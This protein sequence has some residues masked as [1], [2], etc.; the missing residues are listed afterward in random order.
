MRRKVARDDWE[1]KQ[2]INLENLPAIEVEEGTSSVDVFMSVFDALLGGYSFD[3]KCLHK[4]EPFI[5]VEEASVESH[6]NVDQFVENVMD[7]LHWSDDVSFDE[8]RHV[9]EEVLSEYGI[10]LKSRDVKYLK[11]L[12]EQQIR[13]QS[14]P[15]SL[16]YLTKF[17]RILRS[18]GSWDYSRFVSIVSPPIVVNGRSVGGGSVEFLGKVLASL[19]RLEPELFS[20]YETA[21]VADISRAAF[22]NALVTFLSRYFNFVEQAEEEEEV[23]PLLTKKERKMLKDWEEEGSLGISEI[24]NYMC[25]LVD[26]VNAMSYNVKY[27]HDVLK[28]IG[29]VLDYDNP[30]SAYV[31]ALPEDLQ[32]VPI[33][34]L[35]GYLDELNTKLLPEIAKNS[36]ELSINASFSVSIVFPQNTFT[37]DGEA[38]YD[39]NYLKWE[40]QNYGNLVISPASTSLVVDSK[41]V[42]HYFEVDL[43]NLFGN[44]RE[45]KDKFGWIPPS[46]AEKLLRG[47]L[48]TKGY[49]F[50][51]LLFGDVNYKE[52]G[53]ELKHIIWEISNPESD[54]G[55][56]FRHVDEKEEALLMSKHLLQLDLSAFMRSMLN[57]NKLELKNEDALKIKELENEIEKLEYELQNNQDLN[58]SQRRELQEKLDQKKTEREKAQRF[59]MENFAEEKMYEFL[60]ANVK[61]LVLYSALVTVQNMI[62]HMWIKKYFDESSY[63]LVIPLRLHALWLTF[64]PEKIELKVPVIRLIAAEDEDNQYLTVDYYT[65]DNKYIM[66][67]KGFGPDWREHWLG[68]FLA[69]AVEDLAKPKISTKVTLEGG[70][71]PDERFVLDLKHK[72]VK[73]EEGDAVDILLALTLLALRAKKFKEMWLQSFWSKV[74]ELCSKWK[75]NFCEKFKGAD[76]ESTLSIRDIVN[77]VYRWLELLGIHCVSHFAS[78]LITLNISEERLLF[79]IEKTLYGNN[80]YISALEHL[81]GSAFVNYLLILRM[82]LDEFRK[83]PGLLG[84]LVRNRSALVN[85]VR[86]F[87][88][89]QAFKTKAPKLSERMRASI[90][91]ASCYYLTFL[92]PSPREQLVQY[93]DKCVQAVQRKYNRLKYRLTT[94]S[95]NLFMK[96]MPQCFGWSDYIARFKTLINEKLNQL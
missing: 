60:R 16:P 81:F 38:I 79:Y 54:Y 87:V 2:G 67:L 61:D 51:A 10:K 17:V 66:E 31:K 27:I 85:A 77:H 73:V 40:S 68:K 95:L 69:R 8:F 23:E 59:L 75:S 90:M 84:I 62:S 70:L 56:K 47:I 36:K 43:S 4:I 74:D 82:I 49:S 39:G 29:S 94:E 72:T 45:L 12:Y 91:L 6:M 13:V 26:S 30:I 1:D 44:F 96:W 52:L 37:I 58:E 33:S 89:S 50:E 14:L 78:S 80:M 92:S 7:R 65:Y 18:S 83:R 88:M 25:S 57:E 15:K 63:R 55:R 24:K 71:S 22:A 41:S 34:T 20:G 9:V 64:D 28:K 48:R 5:F 35:M 86:M 53:D 46:E 42:A 3:D 93:T 19:Q 21:D 11:K 76:R 32:G